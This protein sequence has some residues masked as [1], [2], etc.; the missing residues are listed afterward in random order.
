[1]WYSNFASF[2]TESV[3]GGLMTVATALER[4]AQFG[5]EYGESTESFD[6]WV[7]QV[8]K[9]NWGD[10]CQ[11]RKVQKHGIAHPACVDALR[12]LQEKYPAEVE[13]FFDP[14]LAELQLQEGRNLLRGDSIEI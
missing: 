4:M 5:K 13:R 11:A 9:M 12:Q 6:A 3:S 8:S 7:A 10:G 1:M 14:L 2:L